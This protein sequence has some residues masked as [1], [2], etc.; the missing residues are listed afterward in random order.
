[1]EG[2]EYKNPPLEKLPR[3]RCGFITSAHAGPV[4]GEGYGY[5]KTLP[6]PHPHPAWTPKVEL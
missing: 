1:M 4:I 5:P 2:G 6:P 3:F